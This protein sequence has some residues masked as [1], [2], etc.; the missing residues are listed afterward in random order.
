MARPEKPVDWK[1][2]DQLLLAGCHGTE[3]APHFD[4]HVNT[5][6]D[7]VVEQYKMSFTEYS[8]LKKVQ[9]D[10][11][12]RAVQFEKALQKDNTMMIWL[13]KNRLG[14]R[15]NEDKSDVAPNDKAL[16]EL[17]N[18]LKSLKEKLNATE[19]KTNSEL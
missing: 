19:P 3:I 9:G 11:L 10:S 16:T 13:G 14:Q 18:E 17:T 2:V 8:T 6:Y 4:M 12:L 5:F 15:E 1:K 7:K